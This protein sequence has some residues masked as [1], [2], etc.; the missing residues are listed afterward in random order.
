MLGVPGGKVILVPWTEQWEKEFISEKQEI[1]TQVGPFFLAIHH[2]GSTAVKNLSA[3]PIIDIAI[4][5]KDKDNAI[6]C[7][8]GLEEL[9]YVYKGETALPERYYLTKGTPR[10]HQ[11]H[12]FHKGNHYI[13][14]HLAF[15]DYLRINEDDRK[16]YEQLKVRLAN[17]HSNDRI[18][19]SDA[20]T[21]FV[22]EILQ[23]L[24][25]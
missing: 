16:R 14:K 21:D 5:I 2:I 6:A 23:K 4:E 18:A 9:G 19:Y 12:M 10:T 13:R 3:K 8:Q 22:K 24:S 7:I 17:T 11:I 20:K 15:R 25:L 1:E